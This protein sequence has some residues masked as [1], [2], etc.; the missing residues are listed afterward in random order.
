V[1]GEISKY[2]KTCTEMITRGAYLPCAGRCSKF[3]PRHDGASSST[4]PDPSLCADCQG[5]PPG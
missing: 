1:D 5:R 3:V 2:C 4:G